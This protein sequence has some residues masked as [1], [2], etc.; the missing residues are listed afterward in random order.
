[1][2]IKIIK[3]N[4]MS[5]IA[6]K[7]NGTKIRIDPFVS[8]AWKWENANELLNKWC[9]IPD[10]TQCYQSNFLPEKIKIIIEEVSK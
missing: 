8:C 6:E 9:E 2:K 1:M 7:E 5:C 3:I 10:D 4:Q